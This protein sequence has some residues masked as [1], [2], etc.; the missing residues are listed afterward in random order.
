MEKI[1][2]K[3]IENINKQ[4]IDT[5]PKEKIKSFLSWVKKLSKE[6]A[7]LL[8]AALIGGLGSALLLRGVFLLAEYN[9]R[10]A[11]Q[12]EFKKAVLNLT[13]YTAQYSPENYQ[14]KYNLAVQLF[15]EERVNEIVP[16]PSGMNELIEKKKNSYDSLIVNLQE[17]MMSF[18]S[19]RD[20]PLDKTLFGEPSKELT[21][22]QELV[23]SQD[24]S[25]DTL[26]K[27][28]LYSQPDDPSENVGVYM[29]D[30]SDISSDSTVYLDSPLTFN[31]SGG[32]NTV[33]FDGDLPISTEHNVDL[34]M[35]EIESI[36]VQTY[37]KGWVN[38]EVLY[39]L[40]S[41]QKEK[42]GS[43]SGSNLS[44]NFSAADYNKQ[45]KSIRMLRFNEIYRKDPVWFFEVLGHELAHA[46]DWSTDNNLS[47]EE[48]L[49][50]LLE[51]HKR[52][53][54]PY[55]FFSSYV[56]K[57]N[58]DDKQLE[59]FRKSKEYFAEICEEYFSNGILLLPQE[60]IQIIERVIKKSD[61][62]YNIEKSLALRREILKAKFPQSFKEIRG[63]FYYLQF[64]HNTKPFDLL[65]YISKR[66]YLM[67]FQFM[68]KNSIDK[69]W[70]KG[71]NSLDK[72]VLPAEA[73]LEVQTFLELRKEDKLLNDI[74]INSDNFEFR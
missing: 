65:E 32:W 35:S 51:V 74:L 8:P 39:I 34:S 1:N 30:Q 20:T 3:K 4:E 6:T 66:N 44:E 57:I 59:N 70:P 38:Q 48:R 52:V 62:N 37:P 17:D 2:T 36:L 7:D 14:Q 49:D 73:P 61:P 50:L 54:S 28:A 53:Q 56:N 40:V 19:I 64:S 67:H 21:Q 18:K 26:E 68:H 63:R 33:S 58:P 31:D 45:N 11:S 16:N 69:Y 60:D 5:Q 22:I 23:A 10:L 27:T 25:K 13:K 42:I 29:S 15:G 9:N 12:D 24:A 43:H 72:V 46:N 41:N 55:S 47:A 71:N